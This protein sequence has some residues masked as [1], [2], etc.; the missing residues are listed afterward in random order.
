MSTHRTEATHRP[1]E[2]NL[3]G[4][5]A[6][7]RSELRLGLGRSH[8]QSRPARIM[9]RVMHFRGRTGERTECEIRFLHDRIFVP[10][11]GHVRQ[12]RA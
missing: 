6:D 3:R 10:A 8:L 2:S 4:Y 7:A 1:L 12:H 5:D 9:L 11:I